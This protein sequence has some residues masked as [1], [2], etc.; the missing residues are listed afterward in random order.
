MV[1]KY[2]NLHRCLDCT[3]VNLDQRLTICRKSNLK[4]SP[5][6]DN[7][8]VGKPWWL[9]AWELKVDKWL[10]VPKN[11][12]TS[13]LST[14]EEMLLVSGFSLT[15]EEKSFNFDSV[16]RVFISTCPQADKQGLF[17]NK[18]ITSIKGWAYIRCEL[19]STCMI[20]SPKHL[21]IV[22]S[23][24][25]LMF[26]IVITMSWW[27]KKWNNH[28]FS[29]VYYRSRPSLCNM[30][31]FALKFRSKSIPYHKLWEQALQSLLQSF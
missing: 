4:W 12:F 17:M 28:A 3:K 25:P 14:K 10:G 1:G 5:E 27:L 15:F 16:A 7:V 26:S 31:L 8:Y 22:L 23:A 30:N 9:V 24:H 29:F 20:V 13:S 21:R 18:T 11:D 6:S 19:A 2:S